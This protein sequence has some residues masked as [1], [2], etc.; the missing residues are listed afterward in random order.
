MHV[1]ESEVNDKD[2]EWV[3]VVVKVVSDASSQQKLKH[4]SSVDHVG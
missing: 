3:F 1:G 2:N 4:E